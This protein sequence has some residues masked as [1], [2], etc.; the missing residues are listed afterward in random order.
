MFYCNLCPSGDYTALRVIC[1]IQSSL[2][3]EVIDSLN[4]R[5]PHDKLLKVLE[6]L[7]TGKGL[8]IVDFY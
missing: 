7:P 4:Y 8:D 2:S 6:M 5:M 1:V 3:L